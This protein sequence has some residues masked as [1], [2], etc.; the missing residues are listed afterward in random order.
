MQPDR[1]TYL[2]SSRAD[3]SAKNK[4]RHSYCC[5]TNLTPA[6]PIK[7]ESV[8]QLGLLIIDSTGHFPLSFFI[9]STSFLF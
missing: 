6:F 4:F 8:G 5:F 3:V 7:S 9:L 2:H 1:P